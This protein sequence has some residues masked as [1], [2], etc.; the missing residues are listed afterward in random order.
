MAWETPRYIVCHG[1]EVIGTFDRL[2]E[3]A[4]FA[5]NSACEMRSRGEHFHKTYVAMA[6]YDDFQYSEGS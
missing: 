4:D 3:A 6:L 1:T 5:E 2:K